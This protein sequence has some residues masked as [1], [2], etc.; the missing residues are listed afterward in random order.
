MS[1]VSRNQF[2]ENIS[3]SPCLAA[4]QPFRL[5][6]F[7]SPSG[8]GGV[9]LAPGGTGFNLDYTQVRCLGQKSSVFLCLYFSC[10]AKS[11]QI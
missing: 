1:S 10:P 7:T 5:G 3:L 6:V 8:P 11:A 2:D 9:D 4:R